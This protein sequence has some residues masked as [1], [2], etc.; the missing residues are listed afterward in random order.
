[1]FFLVDDTPLECR[2]YYCSVVGNEE[3]TEVFIVPR[4]AF[5]AWL[6]QEKNIRKSNKVKM[7]ETAEKGS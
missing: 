4:N 6:S 1:M 3:S 2:H 7:Q 5:G